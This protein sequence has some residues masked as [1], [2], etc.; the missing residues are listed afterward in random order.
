VAPMQ[1]SAL[2]IRQVTAVAT[3]RGLAPPVSYSTPFRRWHDLDDDRLGLA[4]G[5]NGAWRATAR[6]PQPTS[7]RPSTPHSHRP[8]SEVE[9][10]PRADRMPSTW[11]SGATHREAS[12]PHRMT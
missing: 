3:G 4:P 10:S 8:N 5:W 12:A 2:V 7:E 6:R 9:D 1:T 11:H